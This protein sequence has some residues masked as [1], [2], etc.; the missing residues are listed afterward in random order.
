MPQAIHQKDAA[1]DPSEV[2]FQNAFQGHS[3]TRVEIA[4]TRVEIAITRDE[5]AITRDE[6]AI[7]W[8]EIEITWDEIAP[9]GASP[10]H[11]HGVHLGE[12]RGSGQSGLRLDW[13]RGEEIELGAGGARLD[14]AL[15]APGETYRAPYSPH[16]TS[17]RCISVI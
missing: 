16:A 7:T 13:A 12:M 6:I 8:D 10:R 3:I 14:W 17:P 9:N 5:I 11:H 15:Y 1:S 2:A 4:I